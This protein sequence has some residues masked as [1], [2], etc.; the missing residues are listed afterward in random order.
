M[1]T[2]ISYV[3]IPVLKK[4]SSMLEC[5]NAST[6]ICCPQP[7]P[8]FRANLES[9]MPDTTPPIADDSEGFRNVR[10]PS[11]SFGNLPN[12]AEAF[13]SVR[14]VS[15]AQTPQPQKKESHTLTVRQVARLFEEAGVPRTE[16]SIV[17]WCQRNKQGIAK[18][19]A[20]FDRNEQKYF[21]TPHSVEL[22]LQ[23]E[24]AKAK[25]SEPNP[26]LPKA[27]EASESSAPQDNNPD[28][29]TEL[30]AL[31]LEVRDLTITNRAKD[32]IIGLLESDRRESIEKLIT[33]SHKVGQ[34]ETKLLQ[35]TSGPKSNQQD[36]ETETIER[37]GEATPTP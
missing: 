32:H 4:H 37:A 5:W 24:L 28:T 14:N 35:L 20:Y 31:R 34:L 22:A 9:T 10:K 27:S 17:N 36:T 13:G 2:A 21:I 1:S 30:K 26:I 25:A 23:E 7:P 3:L 33:F 11:E 16:R 19:D 6:P 15:E 8:T 18:L 29:A 12:H